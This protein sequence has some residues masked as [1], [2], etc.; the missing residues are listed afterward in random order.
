MTAHNPSIEFIVDDRACAVTDR[1]YSCSDALRALFEAE[2]TAGPL[3]RRAERISAPGQAGSRPWSEWPFP[4]A[5]P[6]QDPA[7]LEFL[8]PELPGLSSGPQTAI[9]LEEA[10][11]R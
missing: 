6:L 11:P 5:S 1:A 10:V 2:T 4:V 7:C 8:S 9:E 3:T